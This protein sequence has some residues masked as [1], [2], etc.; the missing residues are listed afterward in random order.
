MYTHGNSELA[1]DIKSNVAPD[2]QAQM[3][4]DS[5]VI[6][7]FVK[8]AQASEVIL[9]FEDG[10]TKTEGFVT[11]KPKCSQ[12]SPFAEQLGLEM[13]PQ[14][15]IKVNPPFNQTSLKGVFAAGDAANPMQTVT[16]AIFSGTASGGGAPLQ[17]QAE[18]F[19]QKN[20]F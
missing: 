19:G 11:H 20:L 5:R 13:T 6:T 14:N 9:H 18:T 2:L 3:K 15:T 7:K 10:T 1:N 12:R 16:Q 4:V 8:G 17:L